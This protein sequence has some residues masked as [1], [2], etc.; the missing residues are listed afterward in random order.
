M[1]IDFIGSSGHM[2][3]LCNVG[4]C[5]GVAMCFPRSIT[6]KSIDIMIN[7]LGFGCLCTNGGSIVVWP[8]WMMWSEGRHNNGMDAWC[9]LSICPVT[10]SVYLGWC[11]DYYTG[12]MTM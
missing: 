5:A 3:T 9:Q 7:D 8:G 2:P 4:S 11:I 10:T 1:T 12:F 6:S